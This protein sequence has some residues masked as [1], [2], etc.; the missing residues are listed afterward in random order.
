MHQLIDK[1]W[2]DLC[3][4]PDL[5]KALR[6]FTPS[7][8]EENKNLVSAG[9]EQDTIYQLPYWCAKAVGADLQQVDLV[10]NI[11]V[12]FQTAAQLLDTIEDGDEK[13]EPLNKY[14][15]GELINFSTSLIILAELVLSELEKETQFDA[16]AANDLRIQFN[17]QILK[18]CS[19][20]FLDL[21]NTAASLEECWQI[22]EE[23]TGEFF[24]LIC[25]ASARLGTDNADILNKF[26]QF[27][28]HIGTIIQIQDDLTGLWDEDIKKSDLTQSKYSLPVLYALE[29]LP[30]RQAARLRGLIDNPTPE[31]RSSA[32][33]E[34][35]IES[36][37][38]LYLTMEIEKRKSLAQSVLTEIG[39]HE[40]DQIFQ[41]LVKLLNHVSSVAKETNIPD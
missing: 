38:V 4:N 21:R 20:Q 15:Q 35:I 10:T 19:G 11:W 40:N 13:E 14:S 17:R 32:A 41:Q 27:G 29:V 26:K 7:L 8:S 25:Y 16:A 12:L 9:K 1:I 23:K 3:I 31:N 36:G 37:A 30:D 39:Y 33:R 2:I 6:D 5:L 22:T 34:M 24:S 18:M 28:L